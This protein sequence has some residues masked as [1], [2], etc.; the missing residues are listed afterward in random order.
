MMKIITLVIIQ[1]L[2]VDN[3]KHR[4]E[5]QLGMNMKMKEEKLLENGH[6]ILCILLEELLQVIKNLTYL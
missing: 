1:S 2:K 6:R 3:H 5:K 4:W